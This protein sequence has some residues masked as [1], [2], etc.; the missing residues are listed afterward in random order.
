M[1]RIEMKSVGHIIV[2]DVSGPRLPTEEELDVIVELI[3]DELVDLDAA[4]AY[5]DAE[6]KS[7]RLEIGVAASADEY[8]EA[9]AMANSAVRTAIHAA[10]GH[11]PD[12]DVR[13]ADSVSLPV[14]DSEQ[15][16]GHLVG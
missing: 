11:T 3:M 10:G 4:D 14:E 9:I 6:G 7:A 15:D 8:H 2:N 13:W 5:V 1:I 16:D 12:W